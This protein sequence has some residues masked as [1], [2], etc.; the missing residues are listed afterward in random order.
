MTE[1]LGDLRWLAGWRRSR[2]RVVNGEAKR[3]EVVEVATMMMVRLSCIDGDKGKGG[4]FCC[5]R[6]GMDEGESVEIKVVTSPFVDVSL[7]IVE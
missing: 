1:T 6:K 3:D 4:G 7:S 2:K 5:R